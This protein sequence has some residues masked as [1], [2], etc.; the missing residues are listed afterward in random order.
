M[1]NERKCKGGGRS[2]GRET[3]PDLPSSPTSLEYFQGV[4]DIISSLSDEEWNTLTI[5]VPY[6][7][8]K[9]QFASLYTKLMI[10]MSKTA[11]KSYIPSLLHVLGMKV[12]LAAEEKMKL[13]NA[14]S[15][16]VY[17]PDRSAASSENSAQSSPVDLSN[18]VCDTVEEFMNEV[19]VLLQAAVGNV[20]SCKASSFSNNWQM[21]C[22]HVASEMMKI[23]EAK[24]ENTA[25]REDAKKC[26]IDTEA[27]TGEIIIVV[28]NMMKGSSEGRTDENVSDLLTIAAERIRQMSTPLKSEESPSVENM[29]QKPQLQQEELQAIATKAVSQVLLNSAGVWEKASSSSDFPSSPRM[30]A[31][32]EAGFPTLLTQKT[33]TEI[34]N[35]ITE[36]MDMLPSS[37]SSSI[38]RKDDHSGGFPAMN[39]MFHRIHDKVK[40]FYRMTKQSMKES[41]TELLRVSDLEMTAGPSRV[42]KVTTLYHSTSPPS[43][44][45]ITTGDASSEVTVVSD[46][47]IHEMMQELE[48]ISSSSRS[49]SKR[50]L[51]SRDLKG[52][53]DISFPEFVFVNGEAASRSFS[54]LLCQSDLEITEEELESTESPSVPS[55]A[56]SIPTDSTAS[57]ISTTL[58]KPLS[59][60][61]DLESEDETTPPK[62]NFVSAARRLYRSVHK[63]VFG[64]HLG[65]QQAESTKTKLTKEDA[66]LESGNLRQIRTS[67]LRVCPRFQVQIDSCTQEIIGK[68]VEHY[69]SEILLAKPRS[70]KPEFRCLSSP[71]P[72]QPSMRIMRPEEFLNEAVQIVG[73]VLVKSA[74]TQA[75]S[76]ESSTSSSEA[77][78]LSCPHL[79][80]TDLQN[81]AVDI[82][83][84]VV[85]ALDRYAESQISVVK[86]SSE[87]LSGLDAFSHISITSISTEAEPS[88]ME[89]ESHT[90]FK[91]VKNVLHD[92]MGSGKKAPKGISPAVA[93]TDENGSMQAAST[94]SPF[95]VST[96]GS[97]TAA[98]SFSTSDPGEIT[99][100]E[101]DFIVD[102][103]V[104]QNLQ[105][106]HTKINQLQHLIPDELIRQ[107]AERLTEFTEGIF[108]NITESSYVQRR[109]SD[110][111]LEIAW[112]RNALRNTV[113]LPSDQIYSFAEE[114]IN[115][116]LLHLLSHKQTLSN[117]ADLLA[118]GAAS[119]GDVECTSATLD[120][121]D[122]SLTCFSS[123]EKDEQQALLEESGRNHQIPELHI[124][125][126]APSKTPRRVDSA[127]GKETLEKV[128]TSSQDQ[129]HCSS[130]CLLN[131]NRSS[132]PAPV[133]VKKS[134]NWVNLISGKQAAGI[135][136]RINKSSQV[137]PASVSDYHQ[138]SSSSGNSQEESSQR[139]TETPK[140]SNPLT[141]RFVPVKK[142]FPNPFRHRNSTS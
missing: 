45:Q 5:D 15:V 114:S 9:E 8:T 17:L 96:I 120:V 85:E 38:E 71:P 108:R 124:N 99:Y 50:S 11:M 30:E 70:R 113:Q 95:N 125:S 49:S 86:S 13:K 115:S 60:Q 7:G 34:V 88:E 3:P 87:M 67:P 14:A 89:V 32:A 106:T 81:T 51:K 137:C 33:S 119:D 129:S 118:L 31:M 66:D 62:T 74:S 76:S 100:S 94:I 6:T 54:T 132:D 12:V 48:K 130:S 69:K 135:C 61:V 141:K 40:D 56:T 123:Q 10:F 46:W 29:I 110:S 93:E 82:A 107:H 80:S 37:S 83:E 127:V 128:S 97:K 64:F 136:S 109:S 55:L 91:K 28:L 36:N 35:I 57:C 98:L 18:M 77:S 24:I 23:M 139:D 19:N 4:F 44:G 16:S 65:L 140:S 59:D 90:F 142:F 134:S 1:Q 63:K 22:S 112:Q 133:A 103:S 58:Q 73:D 104:S 131:D 25:L 79:S 126:P 39:E 2:S 68:V 47:R 42:P 92:L 122:K 75:S 117:E 21:V 52:S 72:E 111:V 53:K 138:L 105:T 121:Q 102:K 27:T 84:T 41:K 20:A 43:D 78:S 26:E 116:M 101:D